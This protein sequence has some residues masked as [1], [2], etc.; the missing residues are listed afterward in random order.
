MATD[1]NKTAIFMR[2]K[3]CKAACQFYVEAF[4]PPALVKQDHQCEKKGE[5]EVNESINVQTMNMC[6]SKEVK[7]SS[8]EVLLKLEW[9]E[10]TIVKI[11]GAE[12]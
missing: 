7:G 6:P 3:S 2:C 4:R 11:T 9:K 1:N 5:N 12:T 8:N 10:D